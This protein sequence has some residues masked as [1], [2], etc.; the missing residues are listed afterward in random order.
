MTLKTAAIIQRGLPLNL[1][2]EPLTQGPQGGDQEAIL[3]SVILDE[4]QEASRLS[5][6]A[7]SLGIWSS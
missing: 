5:E 7:L 3:E 4:E 6:S 1:K 2:R